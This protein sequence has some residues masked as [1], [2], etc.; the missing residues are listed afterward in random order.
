MSSKPQLGL[1]DR[2]RVVVAGGRRGDHRQEWLSQPS[3][4]TF[5]LL[6]FSSTHTHTH[7][8][9]I[10]VLHIFKYCQGND[11]VR[12]SIDRQRLMISTVF[13]VDLTN[14]TLQL[15]GKS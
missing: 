3:T 9:L 14:M 5:S 1:E 15:K 2:E 8:P 12:S 13:I 10:S 7:T 6:C 11:R 4:N